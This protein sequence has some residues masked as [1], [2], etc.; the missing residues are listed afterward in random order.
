MHRKTTIELSRVDCING[1]V[2]P[3]R[4]FTSP[5]MV[6]K[7]CYTIYGLQKFLQANA[8]LVC[9]IRPCM[10]NRKF[11]K[12]MLTNKKFCETMNGQHIQFGHTWPI[13]NPTDLC[14]NKDKMMYFLIR[15]AWLSFA[16]FHFFPLMCWSVFLSNV[17]NYKEFELKY[18]L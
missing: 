9:P 6:K 3:T 16:M 1:H 7:T 4:V 5:C 10:T 13:R 14:M 15:L 18:S 17:A 8:W 2:W 12:P 11:F